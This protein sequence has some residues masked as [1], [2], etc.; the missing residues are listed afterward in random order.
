MDRDLV[1]DKLDVAL[2]NFRFGILALGTSLFSLPG[3]TGEAFTAFDDPGSVDAS[4]DASSDAAPSLDAGKDAQDASNDVDTDALDDASTD[5]E[6]DATADADAGDPD[7]GGGDGDAPDGDA[8]DDDDAGDGD[9]NA[10]E[11]ADVDD[12][13]GDGGCEPL[14]WYADEDGDGYG[15]ESNTIEACDPPGPE[16]ASKKGDCDDAN[17]KVHPGQSAYFTRAYVHSGS[18]EESFDYD[19]SGTEEDDGKQTKTDE[20]CSLLGGGDLLCQGKDGYLPAEPLRTGPGINPYCGSTTYFT[21]SLK[22]VICETAKI[23]TKALGCR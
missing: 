5:G 3:C 11:D 15:V 13:A 4:T 7:D 6:A 9:A 8:G 21:C 14:T 10:E 20:T 1:G 22:V 12:D 2:K 16:W 19:C 18:A 17:D 23:E